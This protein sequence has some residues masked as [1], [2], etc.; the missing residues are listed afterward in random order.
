MSEIQL[1]F[2]LSWTPLAKKVWGYYADAFHRL[3]DIDVEASALLGAFGRKIA[4]AE[5]IEHGPKM[6]EMSVAQPI[7]NAFYMAGDIEGRWVKLRDRGI[8]EPVLDWG[9]GVGFTLKWMREL[10]FLGLW[11]YEPPGIQRKVISEVGINMVPD[12]PRPSTI[13]CINVLEHLA[14]PWATLDYL[15]S[16]GGRLIANI[17]TGESK[18]H[19]APQ[20]IRQQI[21]QSLKQNGESLD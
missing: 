5:F 8:K 11:A 21:A 6:Y 13:L 2:P 16:L 4:D 10:G 9:C 1:V 12:R 17:D 20:Y 19:I 3:W 7:R 14:N 15:R 18:Q